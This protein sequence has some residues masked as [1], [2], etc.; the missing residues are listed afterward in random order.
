MP[1]IMHRSAS[2]STL[3]RRRWWQSAD[4]PW[5]CLAACME[6]R[7]AL[8]SG[9]PAAFRSRLPVQMDG[10]CNGLQHYAALSRDAPGAHAVNLLP[11]DRP[12]VRAARLLWAWGIWRELKNPMYGEEPAARVSLRHSQH[13]S[14][15]DVREVHSAGAA[16]VC[17]R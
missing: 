4:A 16:L 12:Q 3:A 11:V 7:D 17:E 15:W 14:Y 2:E 5:Q 1:G 6:V 9:D 13:A 10:S 8:A